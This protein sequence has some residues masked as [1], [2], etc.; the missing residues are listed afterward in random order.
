MGR[1]AS[2]PFNNFS[3]MKTAFLLGIHERTRV[4]L[5]PLHNR[6]TPFGELV[7]VE[8]RGLLYGNR[9]CLHDRTGRIRRFYNGKRWIACRLEFKGWRRHPLMQPGRFTELF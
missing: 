8:A 3:A 6:V 7:A 5:T 2:P 4:P 9:G 1:A